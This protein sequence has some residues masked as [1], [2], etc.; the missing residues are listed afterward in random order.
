MKHIVITLSLALIISSSK[1]DDL[2][3]AY[4]Q[5]FRN[6]PAYSENIAKNNAIKSQSTIDRA[7]ILP[8][9]SVNSN[10]SQSR[11]SGINTHTYDTDLT[12]TQTL[13]N[14]SDWLTLAADKQSTK[15]AD[16]SMEASRQDLMQRLTEAYLDVAK[17]QEIVAL[18]NKQLALS[19]ELWEQSQLFFNAGEKT[20]VDVTESQSAYNEDQAKLIVDSVSL[21]DYTA[22]LASITGHY[23][24]LVKTIQDNIPELLPAPLNESAWI[25]KVS[26]HNNVILADQAAVNANNET[27]KAQAANALPTINTSLN[28]GYTKERTDLTTESGSGP[29]VSLNLVIPIYQGGHVAG[30]VEQSHYQYLASFDK[31]QLDKQTLIAQVR[32][33]FIGIIQGIAQLKADKDLIISN[34]KNYQETSFAYAGG[35]RNA[36]D[37][38]LSLNNLYQS[39]LFYLQAKYQYAN[40]IIKLR[41]AVGNL[42]LIDIEKLNAW[43]V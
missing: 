5:A 29:T 28:Y 37:V 35:I 8:N 2:L 4:Q 42:S 41:D 26:L 39:Q 6:D 22:K 34:Q 3:T 25:N 12:V 17:Q 15:Q 30:S 21:N 27:I 43:L 20:D 38:V 10:I 11:I 40:N 24:G 7:T 32:S 16:F 19:K 1:A 13:F 33:S 36:N 9:L 18:D 31:M 14:Y 23:V